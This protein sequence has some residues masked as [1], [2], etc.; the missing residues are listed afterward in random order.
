[1]MTGMIYMYSVSIAIPKMGQVYPSK[2]QQSHPSAHGYD[3]VIGPIANNR[4]GVQLWKYENRLIDLPTLG[5]N[6]QYMKGITIQYFSGTER[7]IK[8]F[9]HHFR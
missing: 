2:P 9:F 6:Q 8:L 7:A 1:M 4:V 5:H 3:V